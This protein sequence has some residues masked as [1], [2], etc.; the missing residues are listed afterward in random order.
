MLQRPKVPST[1]TVS[2]SGALVLYETACRALAEAHSFDEV[3]NIRDKMVALQHWARQAKNTTMIV[4]ATE[5]RMRAER[6]AG[7]LLAKMAERGERE[8]KGGDRKSKSRDATL[9]KP[10]KLADLGINKNP[11]L[12]LAGA[13]RA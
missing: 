3:K 5:I 6:N 13:G 1:A 10:P 11:V 9:I 4:Q 12:P 2:E 8:A 7:E